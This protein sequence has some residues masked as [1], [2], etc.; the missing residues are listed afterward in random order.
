LQMRMRVL[1]DAAVASGEELP[2]LYYRYFRIWFA[3]GWPA[4]IAMALIVWLM[5]FKPAF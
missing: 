5:V 3:L 1:A 4:F 2:P